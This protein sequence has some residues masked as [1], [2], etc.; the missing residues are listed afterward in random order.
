M[1]DSAVDYAGRIMHPIWPGNTSGSLRRSWNTL[2]GKGGP[3][4]PLK[5][6]QRTKAGLHFQLSSGKG[7]TTG[8]ERPIDTASL[9]RDEIAR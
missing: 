3:D 6:E 9:W 5:G 4:A 1:A 2:R 8:S 7:D